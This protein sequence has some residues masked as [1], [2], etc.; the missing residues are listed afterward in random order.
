MDPT[1]SPHGSYPDYVDFRDGTDGFETL[2]LFKPAGMARPITGG[3]RP[4]MAL[5]GEVSANFFRALGVEPYMGRGFLPQEG[6]L[7]APPVAVISHGFWL[8]WFGE[9]PGAIGATLAVAGVPRTVVGIMPRGFYFQ[10]PTDIWLP[11]GAGGPDTEPRE[12]HAWVMLGRMRPEVTLEQAQSQM[13]VITTQLASEYPDTHQNKSLLLTPLSEALAEGYRPALLLL[14][15]AAVLLLLISCGN[16]AGLLMTRAVTR[17]SEMG[18]R[19][20]IGA[21][22]LRLVRQLITEKL[23]I[24][25]VAGGLGTLMALGI[26]RVVLALFPLDFIGLTEIGLSGPMLGAALVV[27]LTTVLLFGVGPALS[28]TS[29]GSAESLRV[30]RQ[31]SS[32]GG[33]SRFRIGVVVAQISLSVVLLSASGLLVRSLANLQAADVGFSWEDLYVGNLFVDPLT[34]PD[35]PSRA[36]FFGELLDDLRRVPG[37]TS[38]SLIDKAPIR[39]PYSNWDVWNPEAP[40]DPSLR[41]RNAYARFVLPEYFETLGLPITQGRD[42]DARESENS[43]PTAIINQAMTEALYPDMDPVGRSLSVNMVMSEVRQ[44]EIIGVVEDMRILSVSEMPPLQMYFHF[45]SMPPGMR[46]NRMNLMVKADERIPGVVEDLR[47]IVLEKEPGAIFS[48][49]VAMEG[50]IHRSFS[51]N[52]V[53]TMALSLFASFA[54]LLTLSGLYAVLA[55]HVVLRRKEIA[56]RISLG[57]PGER[58]L[59]TVAL[60]ALRFVSLGLASG[61]LIALLLTKI[62][63]AYLYQVQA[64]DPMTF[65]VVGL[66]ILI[67]GCLS[68]AVPALNA[69]RTDPMVVLKTD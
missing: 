61:L 18:L 7:G 25:V 12:N 52:R 3:D 44:F 39:H 53:L 55:F 35:V 43:Q 15:G 45:G 30:S 1:V 50:V 26:Q 57:A 32:T 47:R 69:S 22:R 51:G 68:G 58:I 37:I 56:L 42:F 11:V 36:Q 31:S 66:G 13:D 2:A 54:L 23:L 63:T 65:V 38:A 62:L 5:P 48:E 6:T 34:Y 60:R 67:G 64:N 29:L 10:S 21:G 27:S 8:Q 33:E 28:A 46:S 41:P 49:V 40:P 14:M 9:D 24:A 16:A 19:T 20:A 17:R 59:K 4:Q